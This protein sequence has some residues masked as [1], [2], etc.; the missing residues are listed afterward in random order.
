MPATFYTGL[1]CLVA[2]SLFFIVV[3]MSIMHFSKEYYFLRDEKLKVLFADLMQYHQPVEHVLL[4]ITA[5]CA[6]LPLY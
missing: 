1:G 6:V 4:H 5:Y 2:P 3:R